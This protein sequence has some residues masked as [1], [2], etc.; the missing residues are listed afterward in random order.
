M[1]VIVVKCEVVKQIMVVKTPFKIVLDETI[2]ILEHY[3]LPI[4]YG[5]IF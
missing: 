1:W 3:H 4:F 5:I 2:N